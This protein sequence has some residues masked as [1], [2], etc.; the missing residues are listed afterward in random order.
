M[1]FAGLI[2]T[3]RDQGAILKPDPCGSRANQ[4]AT[5]S[6]LWVYKTFFSQ[7]ASIIPI[8]FVFDFAV[9]ELI[10]LISKQQAHQRS[11]WRDMLP[12]WFPFAGARSGSVD[13]SLSIHPIA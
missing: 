13:R 1:D 4:V 12:D 8:D 11:H 10:V 3:Q 9:K 2:P 5:E 6:W 7:L